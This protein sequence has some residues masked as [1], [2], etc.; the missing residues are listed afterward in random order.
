MAMVTICP[1]DYLSVLLALM[2][3]SWFAFAACSLRLLLG[4][5]PCGLYMQLVLHVFVAALALIL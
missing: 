3:A 4:V 2:Y 1:C 5:I